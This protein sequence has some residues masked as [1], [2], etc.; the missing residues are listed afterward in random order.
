MLLRSI[1]K[2]EK[3]QTHK[4]KKKKLGQPQPLKKVAGKMI[5]FNLKKKKETPNKKKHK[6]HR[7]YWTNKTI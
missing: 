1:K 4:K 5:L 7:I 3:L 2:P 6:E